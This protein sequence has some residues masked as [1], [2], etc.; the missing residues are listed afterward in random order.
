MGHEHLRLGR[1]KRFLCR[2]L[3]ISQRS[4]FRFV[5]HVLKYPSKRQF[6]LQSPVFEP[7]F[8]R[9]RSAVL[10]RRDRPE[11]AQDRHQ[12]AVAISKFHSS[13]CNTLGQNTL[14]MVLARALPIDT[15]MFSFMRHKV[16]SE[17]FRNLLK[18]TAMYHLL[19]TLNETSTHRHQLLL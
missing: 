17:M 15:S 16:P 4:H 9:T 14:T 2:G 7:P 10:S 1:I 8:Y 5:F 18:H 12:L 11:E 3:S 13:S 6:A 19:V